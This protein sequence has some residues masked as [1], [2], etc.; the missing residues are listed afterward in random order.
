VEALNVSEKA[1]NHSREAL[2]RS[3]KALKLRAISPNEKTKALN[4]VLPLAN[5]LEYKKR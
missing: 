1:P 2:D 3:E 4:S 5:Q